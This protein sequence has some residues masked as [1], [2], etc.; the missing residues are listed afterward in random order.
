MACTSPAPCPLLW[1]ARPVFHLATWLV[2]VFFTTSSWEAHKNK[3]QPAMYVMAK[4][5]YYLI[6]DANLLGQRTDPDPDSF[7]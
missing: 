3:K 5:K 2:F 4:I 6:Q 1:Q 7:H